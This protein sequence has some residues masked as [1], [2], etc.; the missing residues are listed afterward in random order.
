MTTEINQVLNRLGAVE[1]VT[2][3]EDPTTSRDFLLLG[4]EDENAKVRD[5]VMSNPNTPVEALIK[6]S[7]D[8]DLQVRL[9]VI[10]NPNTPTS[11][12]MSACQDKIP[13]LAAFA[14]YRL[15]EIALSKEQSP[16]LVDG[17]VD[18]EEL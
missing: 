3:M 16:R 13:A 1:R 15:S 4:A 8:E 12:I 11:V 14:R 10:M 2:I 7:V 5:A 9:S 18:E 6:G 17:L